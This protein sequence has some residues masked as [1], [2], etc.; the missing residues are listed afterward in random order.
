M[1]FDG[2][3]DALL[4]GFD[5]VNEEGDDQANQNGAEDD[6]M[7]PNNKSSKSK[8]EDKPMEECE[9]RESGQILETDQ[10]KIVRKA[11]QQLEAASTPVSKLMKIL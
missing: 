3:D 10:Q 2:C 8:A 5:A 1:D 4:S 9:E 6:F 11:V 7:E